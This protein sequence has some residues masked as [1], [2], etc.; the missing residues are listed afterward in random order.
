MGAQYPITGII[1][2]NGTLILQWANNIPGIRWEA[3]QISCY[4]GTVSP[5]GTVAILKNGLLVAP[6]GQLLPIQNGQ[7]GTAAAGLPYLDVDQGDILTFSFAG[8]N[9]NDT[10]TVNVQYEEYYTGSQVPLTGTP[11]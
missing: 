7:Q 5:L 2:S 3:R 8:C 11:G 6:S 9:P 4:T 1:G 10:A